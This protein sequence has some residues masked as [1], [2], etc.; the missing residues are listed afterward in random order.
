MAVTGDGV[1]DAP[2]LSR[3]NVGVTSAALVMGFAPPLRGS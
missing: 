1:N 2:A 3:A